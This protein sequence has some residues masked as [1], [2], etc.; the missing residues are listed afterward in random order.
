VFRRWLRSV[1]HAL[2][3]LHV[4]MA[5]IWLFTLPLTMARFNLI[6]LVGFAVNVLLAP[7]VV[8]ILW[9]GYALL[10]TGLVIPALAGPFAFGFDRGLRLMLGLIESAAAVP[11]GHLYLGGPSDTW[12]VGFYLCAAALASGLPAG[13]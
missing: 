4:T 5:A 6:S 10:L 11:G 7:L 9:C 8:A 3:T 12:L 1:W 2:V 13:R